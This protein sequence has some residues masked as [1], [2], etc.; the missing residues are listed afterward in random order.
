M[1]H[2]DTG[3]IGYRIVCAGGEYPDGEAEFPGC[4]TLL[5]LAVEPA[6]QKEKDE[7]GCCP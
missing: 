7:Q 5:L 3:D 1:S 4:G 6:G 2:E